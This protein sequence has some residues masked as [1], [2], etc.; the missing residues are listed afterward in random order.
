MK[1]DDL[2]IKANGTTLRRAKIMLAVNGNSK[3]LH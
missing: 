2:Y 1:S 3:T